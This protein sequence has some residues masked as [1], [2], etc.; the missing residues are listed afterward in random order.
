M[1]NP[2]AGLIPSYKAALAPFVRRIV[3][4]EVDRRAELMHDGS[5]T[6]QTLADVAAMNGLPLYL[7]SIPGASDL[8]SIHSAATEHYTHACTM[9]AGAFCRLNRARAAVRRGNR[10]AAYDIADDRRDI[11]H[12][13]SRRA[14]VERRLRRIEAAQ[15]ALDA[16]TIAPAARLAA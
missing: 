3:N 14:D 2:D 12:W 15:A 10:Y 4:P 9:L 5:I 6:D 16:L 7:E 8:A 11:G 1:H 13:N